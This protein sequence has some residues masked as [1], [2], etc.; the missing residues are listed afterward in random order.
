MQNEDLL[1]NCSGQ[2]RQWTQSDTC[3]ANEPTTKYLAFEHL[4]HSKRLSSCIGAPGQHSILLRINTARTCISH[5]LYSSS[6][7]LEINAFHNF[8]PTFTQSFSTSRRFSS[9]QWIFHL[10]SSRL[11]FWIRKR[12]LYP[13]MA[14]QALKSAPECTKIWNFQNQKNLGT[15]SNVVMLLIGQQLFTALTLLSTF[16]QK[17]HN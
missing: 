6:D 14:L 16:D 2:Q 1:T 3:W 15:G 11:F 7:R 9:Y 5:Q 17:P 8:C 4:A 10:Y 12:I 13:A